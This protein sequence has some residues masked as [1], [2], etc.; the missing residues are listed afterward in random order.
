MV[1]RGKYWAKGLIKERA[2]TV[3][4]TPEQKD[5][6]LERKDW[7]EVVRRK[8]RVGDKDP[9]QG[10]DGDFRSPVAQKVGKGRGSGG[11]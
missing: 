2:G 6:D 11:N 8:P 7:A 1:D 10:C 9:V 5:S 3:Q 4:D